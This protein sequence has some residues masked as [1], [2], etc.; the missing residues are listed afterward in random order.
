[1]R[2]PSLGQ[3]DPP[4]KGM[5]THSSILAWRIPWAEEPG[6]A[7]VH[8][9]TELDTT[10]VIEHTCEDVRCEQRDV[11]SQGGGSGRLGDAWEPGAGT[12]FS[13]LASLWEDLEGAGGEGGG[14]GDRNGEDM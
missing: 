7:T 14:R 9:I 6:W 13:F 4:V 12:R 3:E 2:V 8:G 1:M 10:K 11:K 5:D